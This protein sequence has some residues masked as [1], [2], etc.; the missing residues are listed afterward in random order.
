MD[1]PVLIQ[2]YGMILKGANS[3]A[4]VAEIIQFLAIKNSVK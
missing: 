3:K 1:M 2:R 4:S